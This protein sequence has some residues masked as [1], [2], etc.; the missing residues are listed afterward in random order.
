MSP[1]KPHHR[2]VLGLWESLLHRPY[3]FEFCLKCPTF[4]PALMKALIA[5]R[6]AFEVTQRQYTHFPPNDGIQPHV[7]AAVQAWPFICACYIGV[8]QTMKLLI[9]RRDAVSASTLRGHNLEHFY[10]LLGSPERNVVVGVLSC[11]SQP[12]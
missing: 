9:R 6:F 12:P 4:P 10:E 5:V 7:I 1:Q 2:W 8:E 3:Y 11:V